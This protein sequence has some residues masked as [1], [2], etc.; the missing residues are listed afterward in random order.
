MCK[1]WKRAAEQEFLWQTFGEREF[2]LSR[3]LPALRRHGWREAY[4]AKAK[5]RSNWNAGKAVHFEWQKCHTSWISSVAICDGR[6]VTGSY[7]RT[8]VVWDRAS[9]QW[10][11]ILKGHGGEGRRTRHSH[12]CTQR[13][14]QSLKENQKKIKKSKD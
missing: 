4:L 5:L 14:K 11:H 12:T 2:G 9:A 7:D 8:V 10:T 13:K 3:D 6:T 1:S